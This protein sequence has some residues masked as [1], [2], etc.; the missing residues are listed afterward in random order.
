MSSS[1]QWL[2][3]LG[4]GD[5]KSQHELEAA[6]CLDGSTC[7]TLQWMNSWITTSSVGGVFDSTQ[8]WTLYVSKRLHASSNPAEIWSQL[9]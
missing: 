9:N 5:V 8:F 7:S 1:F 3:L 4:G 6:V 2:N